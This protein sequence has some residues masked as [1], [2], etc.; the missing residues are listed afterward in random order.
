VRHASDDDGVGAGL[1]ARGHGAVEVAER[2]AMAA[3]APAGSR[4]SSQRASSR[5]SA[6]G[7]AQKS[8][9]AR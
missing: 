4:R 8:A 6:A 3:G 5:L 1:D 9:M 2:A 7:R